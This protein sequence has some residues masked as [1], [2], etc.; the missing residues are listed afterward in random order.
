MPAQ[1]YRSWLP[2]RR[3]RHT[4]LL[5]NTLRRLLQSVDN[6]CD[7][8]LGSRIAF[9]GIA[10]AYFSLQPC[11]IGSATIKIY[12]QL[13]WNAERRDPS[14]I[15]SLSDIPLVMRAKTEHHGSANAI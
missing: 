14:H 3:S 11:R 7:A 12:C 9:S 2:R 10:P 8:L 15:Y 5:P 13:F 1:S 4:S 6:I